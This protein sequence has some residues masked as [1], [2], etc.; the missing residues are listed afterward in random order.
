VTAADTLDLDALREAFA[1][2]GIGARVGFGT[3]PAL[4]VVDAT[5]AFTDSSSPLGTDAE[6]AVE[7]IRSLVDEARAAGIPIVFTAPVYAGPT[8][9]STK[10]PAQREL[11]PDSD[12]VKLH[13]R[14]DR[15]P[16]EKFVEKHH[17]SAFFE[18]DIADHLRERD[19]DT[20]IVT[21]LTTSGCVRATVVDACS[22][23]FRTIVAEEAVA[24]RAELPHLESRFDMDRKYADV[25][26][27]NDV[28][29]HLRGLSGA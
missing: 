12:I 23:G 24:D 28:R 13:P 3:K 15:R 22:L 21:G 1:A 11:T 6:P 7:A 5:R 9:W 19:V 17:P 29:A 4:L 25:T 26:S 27:C 2:R 18:S 8:I 10:I 20:V 14:L 16:D